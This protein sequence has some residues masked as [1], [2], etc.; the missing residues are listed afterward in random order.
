MSETKHTPGPWGPLP[1]RMTAN[2]HGNLRSVEIWSLCRGMQVGVA[3]IFPLEDAGERTANTHLIAA[4]PD[5]A[6]ALERLLRRYD[7]DE[8]ETRFL[9]D[10]PEF[11]AARAALAKAR[12]QA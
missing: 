2:R 5:M 6:E 11:D 12:G 8:D 4:A 10:W 3:K 7:D 1:G 9:I